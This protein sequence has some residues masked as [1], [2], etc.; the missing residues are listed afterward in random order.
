M[1]ELRNC[2]FSG[3]FVTE[4]ALS[5]GAVETKRTVS[6]SVPVGFFSDHDFFPRQLAEK[7]VNFYSIFSSTS[8][9]KGTLSIKSEE[10]NA[11]WL[12]FA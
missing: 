1:R 3:N 4:T 12:N 10:R 8:L 9:S 5:F 11:T 7:S 2:H 6:V